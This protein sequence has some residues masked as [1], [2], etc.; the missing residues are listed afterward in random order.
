MTR[1]VLVLAMV[2][3][4]CSSTGASSEGVD[5]AAES[6]TSDAAS[7]TGDATVEGAAPGTTG[8]SGRETGAD[9]AG[10]FDA[11]VDASSD[12]LSDSMPC[13]GVDAG[14]GPVATPDCQ[15]PADGVTQC[16][17]SDAS[18]CTS[19]EVPGG[20]FYLSY[21]IDLMQQPVLAAD[22][23]P[24][25]LTDPCTVSGFRLDA[26][27]V[28]VGRFRQFVGA[29]ANG[30]GYVPAPGSG[31][32]THLNGG[33]GL[34][35]AAG[36]GAASYEPGWRAS[37]D[38]RVAPTDGNLACDPQYATWTPAPAGR[39][40]LPI[41][42]VS[43]WEA[44]AFCIWDGG[45][46]PSEAE[47]MYAAAGGAQQLEYPWGT[48]DA[49]TQNAYAIYGCNYPDGSG[50]CTG[51]SNIAP[52]GTAALGQSLWGQLDLLGNV[53]ELNIGAPYTS[54]C[55]DCATVSANSSPKGGS[56]RDSLLLA[57]SGIV[58]ATFS[59]RSYFFGF[60]CARVP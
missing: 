13:P 43:W 1:A 12:C 55:T 34:S 2:M 46:L 8:D 57:P 37:D 24:T 36:S 18:C 32:H 29:W 38:G 54:P 22:G 3:C 50:R 17:P 31:K 47:W 40:A 58:P 23:G 41:N 25:N 51:A 5:G 44:Y 21:D 19:P 48:A 15:T 30:S 9:A 49:G 53:W 45:F 27:E 52:V 56:F 7:S 59:D 14:T 60:R 20:S 11:P 6:A 4:G 42:C 26:Y 35:V 39:E 33:Q 28:T 16:G 10:S